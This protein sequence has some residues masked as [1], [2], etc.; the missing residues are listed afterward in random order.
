MPDSGL[1]QVKFQCMEH[2]D[3][4]TIVY[5]LDLA[6]PK[7]VQIAQTLREK[8]CELMHD[9][10]GDVKLGDRPY[11]VPLNEDP[12]WK[13]PST[14]IITASFITPSLV[15]HMPFKLVLSVSNIWNTSCYCIFSLTELLLSPYRIYWT[16]P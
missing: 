2:P 1:L 3:R 7:Q 8:V 13:W 10:F 15:Y 9:E 16:K 11:T 12:K 6:D 14:G 4:Q 5:K